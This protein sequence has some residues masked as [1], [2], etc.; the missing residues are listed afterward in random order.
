[1]LHKRAIRFACAALAT[2]LTLAVPARAEEEFFLTGT[3]DEEELIVGTAD[4][5]DVFEEAEF[6]TAAVWGI[7]DAPDSVEAALNHALDYL[8]GMSSDLN[9]GTEGGEWSLMA[10]ARNERLRPGAKDAYMKNLLAKLEKVQGN[11][12]SMKYTE[13]SRVSLGLGSIGLDPRDVGGYDL[14]TPLFDLDSVSIQGINGPIWALIALDSGNYYPEDQLSY[15]KVLIQAILDQE[16]TDGGWALGGDFNPDKEPDDLCPMAIQALAP[17][18]TG[19]AKVR[20]AVDRALNRW[21]G[22]QSPGGGFG[23]QGD[24]GAGGVEAIAQT[25]IALAAMQTETGEPWL[26]SELFVKDGTLINALLEYQAPNGS[27]CHVKGDGGNNAI[28]TDQATL[29]LTAYFR[30]MTGKTRLYD[31]T[32]MAGQN[33][34][35]PKEIA[36][37][38]AQ[39]SAIP[40]NPTLNDQDAVFAVKGKLAQMGSFEGKQEMLDKVEKLQKEIDRRKAEVEQWDKDM[41]EIPRQGFTLAYKGKVQEMRERYDKL[42]V[43]SRSYLKNA[44]DLGYLEAKIVELEGTK[45]PLAGEKKAETDPTKPTNPQTPARKPSGGG[46]SGTRV[47]TTVE[48]NTVDATVR[49]GVV[50][51]SDFNSVKG[52]KRN[53]R[54]KGKLENGK[55]YTM[56]VAGE[57]ITEA[58]DMKVGIS[59]KSQF[60]DQ[61]LRLAPEAEI[62]TY[63]QL[64]DFPGPM[65]V[66]LP[67]E[68]DDGDYLLL[69]YD[70]AQKRAVEP[71]RVTVDGGVAV[72]MAKK[73]GHYFIAAPGKVVNKSID[74]LDAMKPAETTEAP[75]EAPTETP[76]EAPV[77]A[78]T[79]EEVLLGT[80]PD[81][82][83]PLM[84]GCVIATL[85]IAAVIVLVLVKKRKV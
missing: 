80:G 47:H 76:T 82:N 17:Y 61:I 23:D 35:D 27:F 11:L 58:Y 65:R 4:E 34:V 50:K 39:L 20:E 73:G 33:Q 44:G 83:I 56:T 55:A 6:D 26:D 41:F 75:T 31:M 48:S 16:L 62:F 24:T 70:D 54:I 25:V 37:V 68:L 29:A 63:A 45:F 78:P 14:I 40:N 77:P 19:N 66:E 81:L 22:M 53:L 38:R 72:L 2:V 1:M 67:V 5:Y 71:E 85:A 64:G 84:I 69:R 59:Q 32:D 60:A 30:A 9:V 12:S 42:P 3:A 46:S 74:E 49:D 28:A 57:D 13:Y 52:Q 15:K 51:A 8:D 79:E 7:S 21:S 10:L 18:Y 43:S 36:E